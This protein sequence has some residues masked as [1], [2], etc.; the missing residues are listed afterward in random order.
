VAVVKPGM[1][2]FEMDGIPQELA[3][4]A[5]LSAAYKLPVKCKFVV[6]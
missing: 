2:L 1:M 4:E 3:K 6:K 5:M